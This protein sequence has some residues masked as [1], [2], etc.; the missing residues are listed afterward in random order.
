MRLVVA[1]PLRQARLTKLY[2]DVLTAIKG[3]S[4]DDAMALLQQATKDLGTA[5]DLRRGEAY[6]RYPLDGLV[7]DYVRWVLSETQKFLSAPG[8]R[9]DPC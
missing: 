8:S 1:D 7:A 5:T 2:T 6:S 3:T 4:Q 9:A